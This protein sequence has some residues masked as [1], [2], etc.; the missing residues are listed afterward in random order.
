MLNA[1]GFFVGLLIIG[2]APAPSPPPSPSADMHNL[3]VYGDQWSFYAHEP[4]GWT[5]FTERSGEIGSN[6]YFLHNGETLEQNGSLIRVSIEKK[7]DNAVA[8]D[9][10]A[11]MAR[12]KHDEPDIQFVD[13]QAD[14][15]GG[16][17]FAKIYRRSNGDE[18]VAYVDTAPG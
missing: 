7:I 11:D 16:S 12:F 8:S 6:V 3:I 17:V 14:Y 5:G 9:L 15:P 13:F 10:A 18:Y 1:A 2:T 4:D